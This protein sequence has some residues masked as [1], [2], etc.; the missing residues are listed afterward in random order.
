MSV[1]DLHVVVLVVL[2]SMFLPLVLVVDIMILDIVA[3]WIVLCV[4]AIVY[5][6]LFRSPSLA[7]QE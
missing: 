2:S 4:V 6:L 5:M 1:H 7:A 3:A